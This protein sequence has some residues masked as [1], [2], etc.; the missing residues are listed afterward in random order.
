MKFIP[1]DDKYMENKNAIV[2]SN[3]LK[4]VG[5]VLLIVGVIE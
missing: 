5:Y 3:I 4:V 1:G 2:S